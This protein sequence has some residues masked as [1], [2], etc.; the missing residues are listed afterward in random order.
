MSREPAELFN[1]S[2]LTI[3]FPNSK[4]IPITNQ[5]GGYAC[6]HPLVHGCG[7][8]IIGT[9]EAEKRLMNYFT[10]PKHR[11]W[12]IGDKG[13]DEHDARFI[14]NILVQQT[15][16]NLYKVDRR[17]LAEDQEAWIYVIDDYT[18]TEA[19]LT[20]SNSD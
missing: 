20:W 1:V 18:H 15:Y 11:G 2:G 4:G 10:G 13:I 5:T 6:N 17:R 14:D 9:Q 12:C 19:I 3:I 16:V 8:T 7:F